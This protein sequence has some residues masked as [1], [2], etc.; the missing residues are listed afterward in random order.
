[1]AG[2]SPAILSVVTEQDMESAGVESGRFLEHASSLTGG[3]SQENSAALLLA[4]GQMSLEHPRLASAGQPSR[5]DD[6]PA[7]SLRI[8]PG[9][10]R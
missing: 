9:R 8:A 1:M 10:L 7:R 2:L 3:S 6:Q 5:G 4:S